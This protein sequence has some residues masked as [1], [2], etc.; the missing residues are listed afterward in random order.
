MPL[1]RLDGNL[2]RPCQRAVRPSRARRARL[3]SARHAGCDGPSVMASRAT[4]AVLAVAALAILGANACSSL[5]VGLGGPIAATLPPRTATAAVDLPG[6]HNVVAYADGIVSGG[7]PEGREGLQS[8]QHLGIR[9][10][11]SVDGQTPD[12]ATANALGL[13]YIHLPISYDTVTPNRQQQLAQVIANVEGPIYMHCHHGKH[14]SAAALASAMVLTGKMTV[15]EAEARMRVSGTAKE[16]TGLWE[17]VRRC[18]PL[19]AEAL[20]ADPATFPAITQVTGLVATM[21]EIDAVI[22]LVKQAKDAGWQAPSDHPDLVASK[23]TRRL[24]TLFAN[25]QH[26]IESQAFAA[27]YQT[28]LQ[29][30]IA[31]SA[32]IDAALRQNDLATAEQHLASLTKGCKQCHVSYRDK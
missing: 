16:Y 21:A 19:T 4:P 29:R 20:R 5:Q 28:M 25:L 10:V 32:A 12:V 17:V 13:R 15:A 27:D 31:D 30:S 9:T 7:V 18:Q 11:V 8:L 2:A 23:E 14:R 1:R 3:E 24:A 6:L 26:D 22:D